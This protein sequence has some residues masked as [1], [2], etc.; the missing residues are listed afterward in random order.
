MSA[1]PSI[2]CT[3][4]RSAPPSSR[5]VA[6]LCRSVCGVTG[7]SIPAF[8][9]YFRRIFHAPMRESGRPR[10]LRKSRPSPAPFSSTGRRSRTYI[11]IAPTAFRPI[12]TNRS[13]PPLPKTRTTISSSTM[14]LD[15]IPI[16]SLTRSPA[17][18]ASSSMARSRNARGSSSETAPMM[19]STST[20]ESTSGSTRHFF[21]VSNCSLGSLTT[22]PSARRNRYQVRT[23]EIPRLMLLGARPRS[24]RW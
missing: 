7:F 22:T 21:G 10:A 2:S 12:G 11:A 1:W 3:A 13:L 20:A 6:K 8:S 4:R 14:S 24:F 19:R 17:A 18:Y 23:A 15:R 9:T 5:C 16:H